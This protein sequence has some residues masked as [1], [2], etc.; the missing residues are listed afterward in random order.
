LFTIMVYYS[1]E[2]KRLGLKKTNL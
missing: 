1:S 2:V